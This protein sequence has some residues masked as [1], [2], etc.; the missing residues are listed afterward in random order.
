[1]ERIQRKLRHSQGN[2]N[3]SKPNLYSIHQY[4]QKKAI[5]DG[6]TRWAKTGYEKYLL[7]LNPQRGH[8]AGNPQYGSNTKGDRDTGVRNF[9]GK[10]VQIF[11]CGNPGVT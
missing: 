8:L 4:Q 6:Q 5:W 9:G 1:L 3:N 11:G 10:R 7:R 2:Q